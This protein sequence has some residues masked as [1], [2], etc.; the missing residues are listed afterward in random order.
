M[1]PAAKTL[2]SLSQFFFEKT[3]KKIFLSKKKNSM[4]FFVSCCFTQSFSLVSLTKLYSQKIFWNKYFHLLLNLV[5][6]MKKI[7][8]IL[9][10]KS[11]LERT[12]ND[13]F[14][15][16]CFCVKNK[17]RKKVSFQRNLRNFPR[18]EKKFSSNFFFPPGE[19]NICF[20]SSDSF[21]LISFT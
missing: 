7:P 13:M 9:L 5:P 12:N 15:A 21:S 19:E 2:F 10:Q 11:S 14:E 20:V 3:V 4:D 1:F 8:T 16:K 18:R 6:H 17:V